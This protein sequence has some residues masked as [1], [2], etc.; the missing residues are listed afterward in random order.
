MRKLC[1]LLGLLAFLP[2]TARAQGEAYLGYSYLRVQASPSNLNLNGWNASANFK[3]LPIL[4]FVAD[5]GGNYGTPSGVSTNFH[6]YLFGPQVNFP[7]PVSPFAHALFGITHTN[8]G[9]TRDNA[10]TTGIGGGIDIRAS[11]HVKFRLIQ[12]DYIATHFGG[13]TQNDARLSAGLVFRF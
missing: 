5:F 8:I 11:R 10:F 6:T 2:H 4:G 3:V 1:L 13:S 7:G 9:N 12:G